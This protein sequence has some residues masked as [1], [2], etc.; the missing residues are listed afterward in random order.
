[1]QI[2][3]SWGFEEFPSW[4]KKLSELPLDKFEAQL[5]TYIESHKEWRPNV[6][7]QCQSW[8][9]AGL[10]PRAMTR[11]LDWG[12]KVPIK[13]AMNTASP[14]ND[15]ARFNLDVAVSSSPNCAA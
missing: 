7:G 11:D 13:G 5:R 15:C 14:L 10:Q 9:N 6:Y 2:T 12:V 3:I 4:N 1:M 8:L